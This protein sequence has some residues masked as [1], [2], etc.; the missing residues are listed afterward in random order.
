MPFDVSQ[1][2]LRWSANR[3]RQMVEAYKLGR[4]TAEELER[5]HGITIAELEEWASRKTYLGDV[6]LRQRIVELQPGQWCHRSD[7]L[8]GELAAECGPDLRDLAH[9]RQAVEPSQERGL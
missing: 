4:I 9:R 2:V 3:K 8:V 6:A 7:H 5:L 1:P